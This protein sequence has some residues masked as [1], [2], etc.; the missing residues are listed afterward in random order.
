METTDM[1]NNKKR[2][3]VYRRVKVTNNITKGVY[4]GYVVEEEIRRVHAIGGYWIQTIHIPSDKLRELIFS[5]EYLDKAPNLKRSVE[6]FGKD[7]F[8]ISSY[9]TDTFG[10][11]EEVISANDKLAERFMEHYSYPCYNNE[12]MTEEDEI[13]WEALNENARR[14][15][16]EEEANRQ[17]LPNH[18]PSEIITIQNIETGEE[19]T[20]E[21]K[22]ECMKFLKTSSATFSKFLKGLSKLNKFFKVC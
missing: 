12:F 5:D 9:E 7:N 14:L 11:E 21:N 8:V 3:N 6:R 13:D 1:N 16:A 22:S 18:R 4:F 20:F 10:S 17:K 19:K 15:R 2:Y